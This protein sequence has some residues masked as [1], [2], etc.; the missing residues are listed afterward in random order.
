MDWNQWVKSVAGGTMDSSHI[1]T[2]GSRGQ[3]G[4]QGGLP[5]GS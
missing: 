2:V 4:D 1:G 3:L 5:G